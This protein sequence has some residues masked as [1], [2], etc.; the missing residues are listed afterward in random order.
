MP[1]FPI[2]RMENECPAPSSWKFK[3]GRKMGVPGP[4]IHFPCASQG[5]WAPRKMGAKM[6]AKMDA[7]WRGQKMDAKRMFK[8]VGG[9]WDRELALRLPW[10]RGQPQNRPK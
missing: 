3:N 1:I 7:K 9:N 10:S 4:G 5:K 8:S 2:K 6:G